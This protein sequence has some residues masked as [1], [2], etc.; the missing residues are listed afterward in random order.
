MKE[1]AGMQQGVGRVARAADRDRSWRA[2][3][4][5]RRYGTISELVVKRKE[6]GSRQQLVVKRVNP[7][8]DSG[9]SHERKL[10]SY[11]VEACFYTDH[12]PA[13]LQA[14]RCPIATPLHVCCDLMSS[15]GSMTLL[16]TDLRP[17]YPNNAGQM[18]LQQCRAALTW[19]AGFHAHFW[20]RPTPEGLW[21]QGSYWHLDTRWDEYEAIGPEWAD[22]KAAAKT[23][24]QRLKGFLPSGEHSSKHRTVV[25]GDFKFCAVHGRLGHLGPL[26]LG[27]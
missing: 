1:W 23:I 9:V 12:A 18:S 27:G 20:E 3:N 5:Q 16:L 2:G 24:D 21:A 4:L 11:E 14:G 6:D 10:K 25:H 8:A 26:E 13:L 19:L 7:P 15:G 22:L 17:T